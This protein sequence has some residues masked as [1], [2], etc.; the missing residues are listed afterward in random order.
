MTLRRRAPATLAVIR[1]A[2]ALAAAILGAGTASA[3][4]SAM[5]D[6]FVALTAPAYAALIEADALA[7]GSGSRLARFARRDAAEAE[8]AAG[9]LRAW[10]E[11]TR[12]ADIAA[13]HTPSIDG[14]GPILYPFSSM[15]LPFSVH[16]HV[17]TDPY[18]A[19]LARLA[20]TRGTDFD[21]A[22]APAAATALRR[23]VEAYTDYIEN[24]DDEGLRRLAVRNLPITKRLLAE[25]ER[26]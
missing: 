17:D 14:L 11:A 19:T 9:E 8:K 15:V 18:R 12:Q 16:G 21:A 5:T 22:Y 23:L 25:I 24:G 3:D 10:A 6:A 1:V 7:E 20:A 13:A 4:T 2:S 26:S